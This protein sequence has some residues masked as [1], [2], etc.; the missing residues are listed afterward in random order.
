MNMIESAQGGVELLKRGF[1]VCLDL[2][3]LTC[4]ALLGPK[5]NLL[6]ETFPHKF[7]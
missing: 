4:H 3:C 6:L 5:P 1:N 7:S 2:L